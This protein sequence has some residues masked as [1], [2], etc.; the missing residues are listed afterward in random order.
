MIDE[1]K[2]KQQAVVKLADFSKKKVQEAKISKQEESDQEKGTK[3]I[4]DARSEM[5]SKI[6]TAKMYANKEMEAFK[7]ATKEYLKSIEDLVLFDGI[8]NIIE[9]LMIEQLLNSI[10][11]PVVKG[12]QIP[13]LPE[14]HYRIF[15]TEMYKVL[16]EKYVD[17]Q[18]K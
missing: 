3:S 14:E 1:E 6:A 7:K 2:F 9:D 13:G 18:D 4:K 8:D 12:R 15:R 10:I 11:G 16:I 17:S 5:Q